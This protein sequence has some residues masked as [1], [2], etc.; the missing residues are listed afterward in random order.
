MHIFI[1]IV[2][3]ILLIAFSLLPPLYYLLSA[4]PAGRA[5]MLGHFSGP[6]LVWYYFQVFPQPACGCAFTEYTDSLSLQNAFEQFY[7]SLAG[8]RWFWVAMA[9]YGL[10]TSVLLGWCAWS[11]LPHLGSSTPAVG[12]LP[13]TAMAAICGGYTRTVFD[14]IDDAYSGEMSPASLLYACGRMIISVPIGYAFTLSVSDARALPFL[15]AFIP[16]RSL[17]TFGHRLLIRVIP[18][19]GEDP[20]GNSSESEL[21][22]I[23]GIDRLKAER[24]SQE[25]IT[26]ISQLACG[27]PV[28]LSIRTNLD[29]CYV[30]DCI[31]QALLHK[32]LGDKATLLLSHGL[33]GAREATDLWCQSLGDSASQAKADD[34]L[35]AAAS[36]MG[37]DK[38]QLKSAIAETVRLPHAV[39]ICEMWDVIT[40]ASERLYNERKIRK[41]LEHANRTASTHAA[42]AVLAGQTGVERAEHILKATNAIGIAGPEDV[43]ADKITGLDP[44]EVVTGATQN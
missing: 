25:G 37:I 43:T 18:A 8:R 14:T 23:D 35:R 6:K 44:A 24:F 41:A 27:N 33:R 13:I 36:S 17:F 11:L 30:M 5:R 28:I 20:A 22:K 34:R 16:T 9:A 15:I 1:L 12:M 4:W 39:F 7:D 40:K 19:L 31:S 3:S 38:E 29:F 21:Q 10:I 42:V 32:Y 26:T 2:A